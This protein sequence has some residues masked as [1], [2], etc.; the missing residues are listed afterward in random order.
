[1]ECRRL[2]HRKEAG[3]GNGALDAPAGYDPKP[4]I[5]AL[6]LSAP[7]VDVF[8]TEIADPMNAAGT[9]YV[10]SYSI[11]GQSL[12]G[13]RPVGWTNAAADRSASSAVDL[14]SLTVDA[15][16]FWIVCANRPASK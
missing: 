9:R 8:I 10:E 12:E 1:M 6:S 2:G 5:S 15:G 7:V 3:A 14:S 11:G 4:W 16:G 13:L